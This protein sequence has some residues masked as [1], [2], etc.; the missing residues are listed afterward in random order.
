MSLFTGAL[1]LLALTVCIKAQS[2][3]ELQ[4][5]DVS[6]RRNVRFPC[7]LGVYLSDK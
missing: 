3:N 4:R 5:V 6:Y 1:R 7:V 2:G